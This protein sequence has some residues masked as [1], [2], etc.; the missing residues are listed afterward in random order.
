MS[1]AADLVEKRVGEVLGAHPEA[2]VRRAMPIILL[3][4]ARDFGVD[5]LRP[6]IVSALTEV[7]AKL[8]VHGEMEAAEIE[9]RVGELVRTIPVSRALL[10][11]LERV[12]R[13]LDL[14]EKLEESAQ[15][16][17]LLAQSEPHLKAPRTTDVAPDNSERG[18]T[19]ALN[20]TGRI[21]A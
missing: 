3:L 19:M 12:F 4:L 21:P 6:K 7:L 2:E 15:H 8:G 9:R 18:S 11:D 17:R 14:G 5:N 10:S 16:F 13:T 1:R 20:G